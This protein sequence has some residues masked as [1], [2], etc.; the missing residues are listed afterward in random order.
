MSPMVW[1]CMS[2]SRGSLLR[3]QRSPDIPL[4]T[5]GVDKLEDLCS[6]VMR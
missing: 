5:E 4:R 3:C 2:T 1:M 6:V